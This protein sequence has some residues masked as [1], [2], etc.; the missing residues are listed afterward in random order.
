MGP[1]LSP[2]LGTS[3]ISAATGTIVRESVAAELIQSSCGGGESRPATEGEGVS[4]PDAQANARTFQGSYRTTGEE[5]PAGPR[6]GSRIETAGVASG[7][8]ETAVIVPGR[9]QVTAGLSH[10]PVTHAVEVPRHLIHHAGRLALPP[11][12]PDFPAMEA[13]M[14]DENAPRTSLDPVWADPSPMFLKMVRS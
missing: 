2:A 4:Y 1:R 3:V 14:H 5:A 11:F 13:A 7:S 8:H 6:V 10:N 9:E 12:R